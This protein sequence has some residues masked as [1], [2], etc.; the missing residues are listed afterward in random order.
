MG[1]ENSVFSKKP[2]PRVNSVTC[3]EITVIVET[4]CRNSSSS[5]VAAV[6]PP[7]MTATRSAVIRSCWA[8]RCQNWAM[9]ST[10]GLP[11]QDATARPARAR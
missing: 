5:I 4:R 11:G 1:S 9:D 3:G 2:S 7:P 10:R 6:S 8:A